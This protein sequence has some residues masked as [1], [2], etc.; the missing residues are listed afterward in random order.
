M[1]LEMNAF[2]EVISNFKSDLFKSKK[3]WILYVV[4]VLLAAFSMFGADNYAHPKME[5]GIILL[6]S[7][8]GVFC[9]TYFHGHNNDKELFKTAFIVILTFGIICSFLTPICLSPDEVEHFVRSEMTSRGE[10]IPIYENNT[11]LTIQSTLDLI[12]DSKETV[13]TGFDRI[14]FE[15]A[16]IFKTDADTKPINN[17]LVE[18]PSAFA[19]NSFFGY[20]PQAIGMLVAKLFDLN[21]VWLLWLGRIFNVVLYASLVYIAMKKTPI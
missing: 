16:S 14:H 20:L 5:I 19:Q 8:L 12:E 11:F 4:L 17:T 18:Y 2:L 10:F 6:S 13:D 21:A 9:I 15:N 7:I 1:Y 3:Y